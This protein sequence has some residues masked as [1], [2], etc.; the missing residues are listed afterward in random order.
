MQRTISTIRPNP[1]KLATTRQF[2]YSLCLQTREMNL[3][4]Y[5]FLLLLVF[6]N[7][8]KIAHFPHF[9]FWAFAVY[10]SQRSAE[11]VDD[12]VCGVS[13]EVFPD[14]AR[15]FVAVSLSFGRDLA[16]EFFAAEKFYFIIDF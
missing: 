2:G 5:H 12:A 3:L 16:Y 14:V 15:N 8:V 11:A 10:G 7:S 9:F 6:N 4:H 13:L 1:Y